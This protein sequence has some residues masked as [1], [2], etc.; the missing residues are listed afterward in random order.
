MIGI[1]TKYTILSIYGVVVLSLKK[2]RLDFIWPF[3]NDA[4][5]QSTSH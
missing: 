1:G 4:S 2:D 5:T 3:T